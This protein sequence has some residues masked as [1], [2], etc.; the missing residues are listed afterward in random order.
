MY[1]HVSL[2]EDSAMEVTVKGRF[3]QSQI[4]ALAKKQK[5]SCSPQW[6]IIARFSFHIQALYML[7]N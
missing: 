2:V 1:L 7:M 6:L 4:Q 5:Y 3:I